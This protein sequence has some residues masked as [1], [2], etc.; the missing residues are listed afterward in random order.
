MQREGNKTH[1]GK[2]ENENR[3]TPGAKTAQVFTPFRGLTLPGERSQGGKKNH[4]GKEERRT[5][6]PKLGM[7]HLHASWGGKAAERRVV[8]RKE[9][10]KISG[11]VPRC[12]DKK[13]AC[14][15]GNPLGVTSKGGT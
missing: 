13:P 3:Q 9:L 7:K 2:G 15:L 10:K 11:G 12:G 4:E 14:T 8:M 1:L 5:W 6:D